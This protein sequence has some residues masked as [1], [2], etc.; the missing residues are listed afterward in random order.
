MRGLSISLAASRWPAAQ[1][2]SSRHDLTKSWISRNAVSP[3]VLVFAIPFNFRAIYRCAIMPGTRRDVER[4]LDPETRRRV[5]ASVKG[6]NTKPE[7]LVRQA[8]H[9]AG[10]RFRLHR[11]DLPGC[12]DIVLSARRLAVFVHGC[13]WHQHQDPTCRIRK[14]AGGNNQDYWQPKLARNVARD[15]ARRAELEAMG[16]QT[17]I[18]WECEARDPTRL[19]RAVQLIGA[20][21]ATKG[22]ATK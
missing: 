9:A 8:L 15:D 5:M 20:S 18:I 11:R 1:A 16:W 17:L 13:F 3:M 12:P 19:A 4:H 2:G 21:P 22:R 7:M 10:L 14:S 6:R